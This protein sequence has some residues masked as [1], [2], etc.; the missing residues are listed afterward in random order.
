MKNSEDTKNI[1]G[2]ELSSQISV[3]TSGFHTSQVS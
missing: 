1:S 3:L 2:P